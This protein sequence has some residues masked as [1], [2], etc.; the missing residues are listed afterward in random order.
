VKRYDFGSGLVLAGI[1][2]WVCLKGFELGFG[3]W[4]E[5]GPGF[6]AVLGGAILAGLSL[7]RLLAML[8]RIRQEEP[9]RAFWAEGGAGRRVGLVLGALAGFALLLPVAGFAITCFLL[10][11]FLA[12]TF[13]SKKWRFGLLM[14]ALSTAVSVL[15]FLVWLQV[16]FPDGPLAGTWLR[17][18][19]F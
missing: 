19:G 12:I 1:G 7:V 11:A 9:R 5:P 4:Y 13:E 8:P 18:L 17:T 15:V 16:Q 10:L 3:E 6:V 2:G 14:A